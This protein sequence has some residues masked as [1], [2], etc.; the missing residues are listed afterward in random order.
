M[1]FARASVAGWHQGCSCGER[2]AAGSWHAPF[3]LSFQSSF[4]MISRVDKGGRPAGEH[5]EQGRTAARPRAWQRRRGGGGPRTAGEWPRGPWRRRRAKR[6]PVG[7]TGSEG[8]A[9]PQ[10]LGIDGPR[11]SSPPV[12]VSIAEAWS[13]EEPP[14]PWCIV[15]R[16][17]TALKCQR[18][19]DL[20]SLLPILCKFNFFSICAS[21]FCGFVPFFE[22]TR[23][24][25]SKL[26][27]V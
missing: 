24:F 9:A 27:Q 11:R 25:C 15:T 26:T 4:S 5:A 10:R 23:V 6:I 3:W 14:S 21:V 13:A 12:H 1:L 18:A 22:F 8:C 17:F 16:V 20:S 2:G 7:P 19:M